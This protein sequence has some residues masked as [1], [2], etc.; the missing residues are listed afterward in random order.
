MK[1]FSF[2]ENEKN[3]NFEDNVDKKVRI[4]SLKI[5]Q[6][7]PSVIYTNIIIIRELVNDFY[8]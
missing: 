6:L 5:C 7:V 4:T 1:I 8:S 2:F 3:H